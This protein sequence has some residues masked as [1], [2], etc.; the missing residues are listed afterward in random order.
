MPFTIIEDLRKAKMDCPKD[1][2]QIYER[3]I[4]LENIKTVGIYSKMVCLKMVLV[5]PAFV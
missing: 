1:F 2:V 4:S 3:G 5:E